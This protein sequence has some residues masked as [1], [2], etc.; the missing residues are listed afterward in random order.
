MASAESLCFVSCGRP[1]ERDLSFV[2]SQQRYPFFCYSVCLSPLDR[3]HNIP[4]VH[5]VTFYIPQGSPRCWLDQLRHKILSFWML[6]ISPSQ[7]SSAC[8][9]P[10]KSQHE[11]YLGMSFRF[12]P[13]TQYAYFNLPSFGLSDGRL[14]SM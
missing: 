4:T 14:S 1:P 11:Q 9:I 7:T 5:A 6:Y 3:H 8:R 12:L 13:G 2:L 10:N